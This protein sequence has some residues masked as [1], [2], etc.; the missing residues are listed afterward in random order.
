MEES[1]ISSTKDNRGD[2]TT[3]LPTPLPKMQI[4]IV[5]CIQ[6]CEAFNGSCH[7]IYTL[8]HTMTNIN[9]YHSMWMMVSERAVSVLGIHGRRHGLWRRA[10]GFLCRHASSFVLC[11]SIHQLYPMG[12]RVWHVRKEA[13]D[14]GKTASCSLFHFD[15]SMQLQWL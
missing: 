14:L 10:T 15:A 5:V 6:I 12:D 4:F 13:S 3:D 8:Q 11:C 2:S 7:T 1:H 9:H